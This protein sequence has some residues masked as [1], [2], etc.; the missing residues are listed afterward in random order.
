MEDVVNA[1]LGMKRGDTRVFDLDHVPD[2]LEIA[3]L[4]T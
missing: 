2:L 4:T 3:C 1:C